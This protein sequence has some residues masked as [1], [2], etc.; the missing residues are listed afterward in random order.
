WIKPP[1]KHS[2]EQRKAFA[3]I[4]VTDIQTMNDILCGS[5]R[6]TNEHVGVHKDKKEL[7]CYVKWQR[8]NHITRSYHATVDTCGSYYCSYHCFHRGSCTIL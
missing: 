5:L 8:I 2:V 4:Q 7:L 3:L 6:I 1:L